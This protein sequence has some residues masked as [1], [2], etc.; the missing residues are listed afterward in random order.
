MK[1]T[2]QIYRLY[3][4]SRIIGSPGMKIEGFLEM[5]GD[6]DRTLSMR[7]GINIDRGEG[8]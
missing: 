6:K 5:F 8:L 1:E 3:G 4:V 7:K 2:I